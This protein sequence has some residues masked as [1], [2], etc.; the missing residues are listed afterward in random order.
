[1]GK[2]DDENIHIDLGSDQTSCTTLAGGY[3]PDLS[4]E[5][6]NEMMANDPDLFKEKYK[7][8][9]ADIPPPS[10]NIL[11]GTYFDYGNAFLL[12]ASRVVLIS[13]PKKSYRLQVSKLR[14]RHHGTHVF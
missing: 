14:S 10:T 8:H 1:L 11:K 13:W 7:K 2:F 9:Y 5:E 3:Y 12:E 6:A 4:F